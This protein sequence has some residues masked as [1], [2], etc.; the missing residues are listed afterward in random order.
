MELPHEDFYRNMRTE[1]AAVNEMVAGINLARADRIASLQTDASPL[2]Q[3]ELAVAAMQVADVGAD[4][5]ARRRR[6][7][8]AGAYEIS[9]QSG[10]GE[11]LAVKEQVFDRLSAAVERV[12]SRLVQLHG[13]DDA[14]AMIASRAAGVV[15]RKLVNGVLATGNASAA[16]VCQKEIMLLVDKEIKED[17]GEQW[18]ALTKEQQHQIARVW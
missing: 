3:R 8:G 1:L 17:M 18:S 2:D 13:A 6:W 16:L 12:R 11:A 7:Y 4:G 5:R 15:M 10:K 14:D 9:D